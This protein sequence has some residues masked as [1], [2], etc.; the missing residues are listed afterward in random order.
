ML[1]LKAACLTYILNP[2]MGITLNL[3]AGLEKHD[4]RLEIVR[5]FS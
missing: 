1:F 5:R 3:L 4:N 2:I